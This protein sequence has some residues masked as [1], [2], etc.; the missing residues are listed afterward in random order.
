MTMIKKKEAASFS[1]TLYNVKRFS[2]TPNN[3][4]PMKIPRGLSSPPMMATAN[5]F[6]PRNSPINAPGCTIGPTKMPPTPANTPDMI[7]AIEAM[8]RGLM[9]MSEG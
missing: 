6:K 4:P 9:P 8:R 1:D 2:I 3:S 5:A 7:K